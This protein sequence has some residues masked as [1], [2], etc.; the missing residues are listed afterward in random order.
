MRYQFELIDGKY[1]TVRLDPE[2]ILLKHYLVSEISSIGDVDEILEICSEIFRGQ[3]DSY[4]MGGNATTIYIRPSEVEI[5]MDVGANA[6]ERL[7]IAL[8]LFE[9]I[10]QG[11][12]DHLIKASET[13]RSER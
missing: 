10:V 3:R 9:E 2:Y 1:P 6:G 5:E 7:R 8:T 11:W 4:E 12:R 13:D